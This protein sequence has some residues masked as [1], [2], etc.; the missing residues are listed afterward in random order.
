MFLVFSAIVDLKQGTQLPSAMNSLFHNNLS[1]TLGPWFSPFQL[2][3]SKKVKFRTHLKTPYS[4]ASVGYIQSQTKYPISMPI[5]TPYFS[6]FSGIRGLNLST[7][8][9][10]CKQVKGLLKAQLGTLV[11][12]KIMCSIKQKRQ[13][14]SLDPILNVISIYVLH[15][16]ALKLQARSNNFLKTLGRQ[17]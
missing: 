17:I 2:A 13:N 14:I 1:A 9:L 15:I 6:V 12:S 5:Q 11:R 3:S 10:Y 4:L 7:Q 8:L 16:K